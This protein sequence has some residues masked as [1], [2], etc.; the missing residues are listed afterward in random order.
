M[1]NYM[2]DLN[3]ES[4]RGKKKLNKGTEQKR[5]KIEI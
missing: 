5:I 4:T 3:L 1:G 2:K